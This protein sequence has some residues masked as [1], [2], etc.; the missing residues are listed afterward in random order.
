MYLQ[1]LFGQGGRVGTSVQKVGSTAGGVV[2]DSVGGVELVDGPAVV[3]GGS[4]PQVYWKGSSCHDPGGW[5]N[6][7]ITFTAYFMLSEENVLA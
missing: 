3:D 6:L 2:V 5:V 7:P 4:S 1:N